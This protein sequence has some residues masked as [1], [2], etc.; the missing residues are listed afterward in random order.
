L[1]SL[2]IAIHTQALSQSRPMTVRQGSEAGKEW[3]EAYP[4][5]GYLEPGAAKL[6]HDA[7][8]ASELSTGEVVYRIGSPC[9]AYVLVVEGRTRVQRTSDSG[10]EIVLYRVGAGET[11][12]LTTS[13]LLSGSCYPAESFAETPVRKVEIPAA[14]FHRLMS[15]SPRFR[16]FVFKNYGTLINE[17]ILLVEEV[18]FRH[19][20]VRLARLL[21]SAPAGIIHSTH[22]QLAVDLGSVREVVSR[23]LKEFERRGWVRLSRA[24]I[25]VTDAI[26][27]QQTAGVTEITDR[28]QLP[29]V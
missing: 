16:D 17:L 13:C 4:D 2:L 15:E 7:S 18:A 1:T 23:Q 25:L 21:L 9:Q 10:R 22:E 8:R 20:D 24:Q 12:V 5:L 26:A 14:V 3:I 11:C 28:A 27:L 6:L 19:L 29:A